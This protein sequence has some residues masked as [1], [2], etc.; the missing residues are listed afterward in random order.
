MT[1]GVLYFVT[2]N[3][4]EAT[5]NARPSDNFLSST[6]KTLEGFLNIKARTL[7]VTDEN[8][9]MLHT[10]VNEADSKLAR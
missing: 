7:P 3:S 5:G 4:Y 1:G 9:V 10:K 8:V 6:L 2:R